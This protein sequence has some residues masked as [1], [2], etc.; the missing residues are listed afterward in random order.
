MGGID[1]EPD[2]ER[3]LDFNDHLSS[4]GHQWRDETTAKDM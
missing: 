3:R 1:A 4:L 2:G